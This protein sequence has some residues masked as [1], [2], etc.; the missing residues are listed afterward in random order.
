MNVKAAWTARRTRSI[1]ASR[2]GCP[3]HCSWFVWRD[4][5]KK[6]SHGNER[7]AAS[8]DPDCCGLDGHCCQEGKTNCQVQ[9]FFGKTW[10]QTTTKVWKVFLT[11]V[12][13]VFPPPPPLHKMLALTFLMCL[14]QAC[15]PTS[16]R[17]EF[18]CVTASMQNALRQTMLV[19]LCVSAPLG[20]KD[21]TLNKNKRV[22]RTSASQHLMR[23][24][25][26]QAPGARSGPPHPFYEA[27]ESKFLRVMFY[28]RIISWN[29]QCT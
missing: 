6:K 10:H 25:Q 16:W 13:C 8:S 11:F 14:Q 21:R 5:E 12:K 1:Q 19:G 29:H 26:T 24:W 15:L 2:R 7:V 23:G 18:V 9:H 22:I 17:E 28:L 4:R 20:A 3:H 27:R